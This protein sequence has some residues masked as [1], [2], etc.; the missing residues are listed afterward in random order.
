V[1]KKGQAKPKRHR[2]DTP[3]HQ[4]PAVPPQRQ[5]E[6]RQV[7]V[8]AI[9][10]S[11]VI[12]AIDI[13]HLERLR[14]AARLPAIKVWEVM[15]GVYRGI[16]GYHR[17][18]V[19]RDRGEGHVLA[20]LYRFASSSEGEK[21]FLTKAQ[22]DA[23]ILGFWS[24]WGRADGRPHGETLDSIGKLFGL[25][26][27]RVHQIVSLNA[28]SDEPSGEHGFSSFAR[29][30]AATRRMSTL[31]ADSAFLDQLVD[32]RADDVLNGLRELD[33]AISAVLARHTSRQ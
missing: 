3:K 5:P 33:H 10:W 1:S 9:E 11:F 23:A 28:G 19:A 18:R 30:T 20:I 7:P 25:T 29:F 16:D 13:T 12:R 31:L 6:V 14:G 32:E 2:H 24:R 27:Q 17:W 15:P 21:A 8:N 4:T 22:R 26:R